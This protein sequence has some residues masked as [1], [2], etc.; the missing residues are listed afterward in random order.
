MIIL[1]TLMFTIDM[2]QER[3]DDYNIYSSLF[4]STLISS[5]VTFMLF[6]VDKVIYVMM[7][8]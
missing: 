3:S 7:R 4:T 5:F 1:S 6:A 8:G 2:K